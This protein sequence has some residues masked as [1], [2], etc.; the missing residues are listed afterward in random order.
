[1]LGTAIGIKFA[2][3]YASIFMDTLE[4]K[5]KILKNIFVK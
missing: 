2:P 1:M 3:T 4:K 5:K